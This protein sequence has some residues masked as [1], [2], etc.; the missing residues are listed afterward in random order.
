MIQTLKP[1]KA[2]ENT[3]TVYHNRPWEQFKHIQKGLEGSPGV[4]LSFYEGVVEIFMAR[5]PHAI[6]TFREAILQG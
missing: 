2:P 1:H 4:R 3:V 5:Q 6:Q